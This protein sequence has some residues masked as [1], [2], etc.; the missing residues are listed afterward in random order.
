MLLIPFRG[1]GDGNHRVNLRE[2]SVKR[3]CQKSFSLSFFL[4]GI[5][6]ALGM[7]NL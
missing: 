5:V 7:N 6:D 2:E 1:F 3:L 4:T